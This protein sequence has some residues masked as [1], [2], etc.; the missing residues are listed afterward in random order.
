M[1][2]RKLT[3][4]ERLKHSATIMRYVEEFALLTATVAAILMADIIQ[5]LMEGDTVDNSDLNLNI[6]NIIASSILA[7]VVYGKRYTNFKETDR[8]KPPFLLRLSDAI[9]YG[10]GFRGIV[11]IGTTKG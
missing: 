11:G 7:V 2:K 8:K 1:P 6:V 9:I 10:I 4:E 3:A 5:R